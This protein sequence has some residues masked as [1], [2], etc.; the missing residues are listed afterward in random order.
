MTLVI[1]ILWFSTSSTYGKELI[2]FSKAN[3]AP[4]HFVSKNDAASGY[5]VEIAKEAIK[6]AGH[7]PILKP[8]PWKRA[9]IESQMGAGLITGFSKTLEREKSYLFTAP[10]YKDHV[11]LVFNRE[12][13]FSFNEMEDLLSKTIGLGRGSNYSGE[14]SKYRHL[15]TFEE[16][17][18]HIQRLSKLA[19]GRLDAGIFPGN[20]YTV[21]YNAKIAGL[22]PDMF[23]AAKKVISTDPNYIG[24]PL[25][26]K[27]IDILKLKESLNL[28]INQ[29]ISDGTVKA[30]LKKYE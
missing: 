9:L 2:V 20:I 8:R 13:V 21:I 27:N 24:I 7:T 26:L 6:R 3:G 22:K 1:F 16:D 28:A 23:V 18:G 4:K 10:L 29:M 5:A 17:D 11:I 12:H 30:I 15:L 19:L 25:A 14:F